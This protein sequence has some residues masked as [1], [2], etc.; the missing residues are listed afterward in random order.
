[1]KTVTSFFNILF[2]SLFFQINAQ[3]IPER[4][5]I[6]DTAQMNDLQKT[7]NEQNDMLNTMYLES[8]K[9]KLAE[10]EQ[11]RINDSLTRIR[12][13]NQLLALRTSDN[14]KK[15]ELLNQLE[16]L[17]Q[18][19]SLRI[20]RKR[21]EVHS[22]KNMAKGYPVKGPLNDTIFFIY[23]KLGSFSAY[24]R[25][26]R[27]T[28][29]IKTL[30]DNDFLQSDSILIT[31]A[32]NLIY[33]MYNDLIITSISEMDALWSDFS[34]LELAQKNIDAIKVSIEKAKE[35][36][37]LKRTL[38]RSGLALLVVL[39]AIFFIWLTNWLYLRILHYIALR[40]DT[41]LRDLS[42]KDYTFLSVKQELSILL[43][44]LNILRWILILST[45][46]FIL[47]LVFSIFPFTRGWAD[48]LFG[49]V[50]APL[51]KVLLS[52]WHYLP[53]AFTILVIYFVM[54]YVI[55]FVRYIFS[56][57]EANKLKI[58]GF[59]AD[60]AMPTFH[61]VRFLMLAFA[62]V[63][64]FP[65]LPGADSDVFK[66][67]SVFLGVLFSLG[68]SSAVANM[69]AGLVITYMRPFKIGDRIKIGDTVGDVI[70]KNILVTRLK[71]IK[72][73]EITIP[74]STILTGNTVNY[75]TYSKTSGLIIH[76]TMTMGY[77]YPWQNVHEALI[78][79][80]L[81]TAA[82]MKDPKPFVLQ[83]SLDDFYVSYQLNAHIQNANDQVDIYSELHQHIQDVFNER[84]LEMVSP[85]YQ[86]VRDGN[87]KTFPK[88]FL[89]KDYETPAFHVQI[90]N[91]ENGK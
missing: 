75:S 57:I 61:I 38:M 28:A 13:E 18:K 2:F 73:E 34:M 65:Y 29:N 49:L 51:R 66:G 24:N 30:Y 68:S 87:R 42:Y 86:S 90:K 69:I 20:A 45:F 62:F 58:N 47:P 54:K 52:F 4:H 17:Q 11:I 70:E 37:S 10:L 84:G 19:D 79:A 41:L 6:Q 22:L 44:S 39:L 23:N 35:Q 59:H 53:N 7:E 71:T 50:W 43:T 72:N 33:L 25:A 83:S 76:T 80:A 3:H 81:R 36:N 91:T 15:E 48:Y 31:H 1:M 56:E 88:D 32:E 40:K 27:A 89:P 74:N 67:V 82:I 26:A 21:V 12:L 5:L 55:H 85:Y 63:L 14:L 9:A 77:D 46:Y 64:I 8:Y 78:E 16:I 60:W